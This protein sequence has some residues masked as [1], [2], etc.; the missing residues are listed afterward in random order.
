MTIARIRKFRAIGV[1][2][3]IAHQTLATLL[4][5][6]RVYIR[7]YID[8]RIDL[9]SQILN[10]INISSFI[11]KQI[12]LKSQIPEFIRLSSFI[13]EQIVIQSKIKRY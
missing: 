10:S 12:D 7:S 4:S 11:D 6:N 2:I 13:D 9:K 3:S 8:K 5:S 1:L